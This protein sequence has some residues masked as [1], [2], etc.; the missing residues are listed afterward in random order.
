MQANLLHFAERN[1]DDSATYGPD[2]FSDLT[3]DEFKAQQASCFSDKGFDTIPAAPASL[4][5]LLVADAEGQMPSVDWRDPAANPARVNAVTPPKNQGAYGY[6]WAF[7]ATGALEGMNAIQQKNAL[8]ALSEQ[9]LIDCC[10]PANQG[11][12]QCWGHGPNMAWNFLINNTGGQDATEASYPYNLHSRKG[13]NNQTC[14][15]KSGTMLFSLH[16]PACTSRSFL[17]ELCRCCR[18]DCQ[19]HDPRRRY[20]PWQMQWQRRRRR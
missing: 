19:W 9:E 11:A 20:R 2:Q 3:L 14:A 6:C 1:R 4:T 12:L 13:N 16:K 10:S 7:G 18:Q 8:V 15:I 17:A 5:M